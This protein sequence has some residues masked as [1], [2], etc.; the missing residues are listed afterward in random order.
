[1]TSCPQMA[2]TIQPGRRDIIPGKGR[3]IFQADNAQLVRSTGA[4]VSVMV[5]QDYKSSPQ[6]S[7]PLESGQV[8]IGDMVF[9]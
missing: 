9:G 3:I 6:K 2:L 7:R 5:L 4:N 8:A 1:M